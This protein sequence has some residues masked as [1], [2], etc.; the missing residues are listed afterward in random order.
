[1]QKRELLYEGKAKQVYSTDD[2]T[3][4]VLRHKDDASAFNGVKRA[5]IENKGAFN[6]AISTRLFQMLA[7]HGIPTHLIATL[8]DNEQLCER[9]EIFPLEVIIRNVIAGSM[10]ARLG[11]AEGVVP[12]N[13]IYELSYKNDMFNDPL[14]N[15]DHAVALGLAS[16]DDL[17]RIKQLTLQVNELLRDYF[18][19]LGITLVDFKVEF[20]RA[21]DGRILLADEISPDSCRLWD[22]TTGEKL[23]KDRFR[24][25]LGNV[26]GAYA[27]ILNR[28][29]T[30]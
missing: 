6:T 27:E 4:V 15:E 16:Y 11:I 29:S 25:D 24:R 9:V 18:E 7:D 28:V 13:V 10:A 22:I 19:R 2:P 26:A 21:A 3:R 20:G 5:S 12:G 17:A 30:T 8:N 14:I 1:M 23:D